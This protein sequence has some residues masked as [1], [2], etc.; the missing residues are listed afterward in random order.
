MLLHCRLKGRR[1]TADRAL[2]LDIRMTTER[3]GQDPAERRVT[4]DVQN[5]GGR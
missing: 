2:N 4:L 1:P 3:M 5:P